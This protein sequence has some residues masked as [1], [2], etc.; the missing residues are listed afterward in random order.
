MAPQRVRLLVAGLGLLAAAC[1]SSGPEKV[2]CFVG[3]QMAP[4]ELELLYLSSA[5]V[6]MPIKDMTEVPLLDAPQG[7]KHMLIGVQA[8]NIDGCPLN[9]TAALTEVASSRVISLERRPI[10]LAVEGG[11]LRPSQQDVDGN[12]SNL[13]ACPRAGISQPVNSS[14]YKLQ[15]E[16]EDPTGRKAQVSNVIIPTCGDPADFKRCSCL[17]SPT[18]RLGSVCQ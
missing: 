15:L 11:V 6:L 1:S 17:C 5:G 18:Y 4:P 2:S 13:P 14:P 16:V 7:G 3:D 10:N 8:R 12:Y 9:V